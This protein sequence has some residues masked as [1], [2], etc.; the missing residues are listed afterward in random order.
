VIKV[1]MVLSIWSNHPTDKLIISQI[2]A[3][4]PADWNGTTFKNDKL[5]GRNGFALNLNRLIATVSEQRTVI[6]TADLE[7]LGNA[8]DYLR[9][10]SNISTTLEV[11]L[12]RQRDLPVDQVFTF[13]SQTM[14]VIAV[15]LT[16]EKPVKLFFGSHT[17]HPFKT[18]LI[19]LLALFG[20]KLTV[21][22]GCPDQKTDGEIVL[23]YEALDEY[24]PCEKVDAIV[25]QNSL[26]I[27]K[28]QNI[29]P[30]DLLVIRKRMSTPITSPMAI[31]M[32]K[33]IAGIEDEPQFTLPHED[34]LAEL[35]AHL[36]VLS[37]TEANPA[38]NPVIGTAG[39]PTCASLWYTLASRGG[40]ELLMASTAY[41]G[42]SQL[43]DVLT[44]RTDRLRKHTFHI[45]GQSRIVES[46]KE[47]LE[48]LAAQ[49]PATLLPL[50]VLFVEIPS[51]P[52]QKI[53][54]V[55]ELA[56]M[57]KSFEE[58]TKKP[59]LLLLDTT[60]AP[61]SRVMQQLS[62]VTTELPV[63]TFISM[64]KSISRGLTTAGTLVANHSPFAVD[65]LKHV[66]VTASIL[67]SY[68][69]PDQL[70]RLV[71]NHQGVEDRCRRAYQAAS[72]VGEHLQAV[73]KRICNSDMALSFPTP[74]QAALGFTSSTFSFNLPPLAGASIEENEG[75]AQRF[76]DLLCEEKV[77][78]KPCVSFGQD[79]KL[80]YVTV[81]AT[82]TQGAIK[83][84][85]KAKQAVGGVQL[86]RISFPPVLDLAAV[87][88]AFEKSIVGLYTSN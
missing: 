9:V 75:L 64:S 23:L 20:G 15:V 41:G 28:P 27:L 56:E 72:Q 7:S 21:Q 66:S 14:P 58:R 34:D 48:L 70:T 24:Q 35:Y 22:G 65:L 32:L 52:D 38:C 76:V 10:A 11:F 77:L 88:S 5:L 4:L 13:S 31:D 42:S 12:G 40:A 37:G 62:D 33:Q 82:S 18:E 78:F 51:N 86:V 43:V 1:Y 29:S 60:F 16:T 54:P 25:S 71:Q 68:A 50:I 19:D 46:I 6:N 45:Q 83:P 3:A 69:K 55:H 8:E 81:P 53:P 87:N 80:I 61:G 59:L 67:D 47:Q 49:D 30:S 44:S 73:V 74:Q 26:F 63:I 85:D 84:E 79:N 17:D 39:L 2:L 36:Q 57:I